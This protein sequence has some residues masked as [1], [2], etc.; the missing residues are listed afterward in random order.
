MATALL[1]VGVMA[2]AGSNVVAVTRQPLPLVWPLL[3]VYVT[4]CLVPLEDVMSGL[5]RTGGR[6]SIVR[7]V[8]FGLVSALLV[9]GG[10]VA[11]WLDDVPIAW[12]L[13]LT[14]VGLTAFLL[15]A[16]P[17]WASALVFGQSMVCLEFMTPIRPISGLLAPLPW[18][19]ACT[20]F[21][22]AGVSYVFLAPARAL[23]MRQS[24]ARSSA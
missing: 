7:A 17:A 1:G 20:A 23:S 6:D 22:V 16:W 19:V 4:V 5:E 14:A 10:S 13:T 3:V 21:I 24:R 12:P 11:A 15:A 8:R 2:F 18:Q 9:A